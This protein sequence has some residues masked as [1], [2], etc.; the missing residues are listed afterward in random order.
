LADVR[1][2]RDDRIAPGT[3]MAVGAMG[4]AV[5]AIALDF[6][7]LS[8]A[9][10]SIQDEFN[11]D[12]ASVQWV[13]SA[14]ALVFGVFIV[15]GGRLADVFGRRRIFFTGAA[16]FA[17]FSVVGGAAPD[18]WS[19]IAARALMGIGGA[20][21]WPAILGMTYAALGETRAALAGAL[22]IGVAGTGN[23]FGPLLG[24]L[25]IHIAS[26]RWILFLN[27]P[28]AA[29]ACLVTWAKIRPTPS[30]PHR[31]SIDYAGILT[32]SLALVSLLLALDQG[33][34]WGFG[35]LR[36]ALLIGGFAMFMVAF[37]AAERRAGGHALVPRDVLHNREFAGASLA[38]VLLAGSSFAAPIYLPVLLR[39][40]LGYGALVAGAALFPLMAVSAVFSFVS[41]PLYARFRPKLVTSAGAAA[42]ALG[43]LLLAATVG[44]LR[45]PPLVPGMALLG[46]G[47]GL[48]VS[49]ATTAGVTALGAA[50]RSLA[51]GILYMFQLVGGSVALAL[52]TAIFTAASEAR[53][54]EDRLAG[55]LSEGEEQALIGLLANTG[56][57]E[58]IVERFPSRAAPLESL[59][60][61]AF[62][63]GIET[64]FAVIAMLALAGLVVAALWVG[65][66]R[67]AP[68]AEELSAARR[69][70][71][72]RRS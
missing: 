7:A 54:H 4:L 37:V 56:F 30:A 67:R 68:V 14:Y 47:I 26:W 3:L 63:S 34:D 35:D 2:A 45:Y 9:L 40:L 59:A 61:D 49:A 66:R 28:I 41:G 48:F 17:T 44:A 8:V 32:L 33:N 1:P 27:L 51:G 25:L 19:L 38:I 42:M 22:V 58:Q 36:I 12:V 5:L 69:V 53:V 18:H 72:G 29:V 20:M 57:A 50:R 24:G 46:L 43:M 31:E 55:L 6:S 62:V 71:P 10:P 15:T 21:M 39:E 60:Q 16:I 65:G 23:A 52:T 13:M 11:A 70:G 64:S